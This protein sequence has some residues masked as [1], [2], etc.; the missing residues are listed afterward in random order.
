MFACCRMEC[1][2]SFSPSLVCCTFPHFPEG[3]SPRIFTS[4]WVCPLYANGQFSHCSSYFSSTITKNR[5]GSFRSQM[6][7]HLGRTSAMRFYSI[8]CLWFCLDGNRCIILIG[9]M[10]LSFNSDL[11]ICL[12]LLWC[13]FYSN[14]MS[15]APR[16]AFLYATLFLFISNSKSSNAIIF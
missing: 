13:F 1:F 6:L 16:F 3:E 2:Y 5:I 15:K 9:F 10:L 11:F 8:F 4:R 14:S 12:F 7:C